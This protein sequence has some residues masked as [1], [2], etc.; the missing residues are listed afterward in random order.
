MQKLGVRNRLEA[1]LVGQKRQRPSAPFPPIDA[2]ASMAPEPS[3]YP[4]KST[5]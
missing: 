5:I 4:M 1:V 2:T 3:T